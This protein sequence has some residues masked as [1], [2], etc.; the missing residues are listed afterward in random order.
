[1]RPL[2]GPEGRTKPFRSTQ[3]GVPGLLRASCPRSDARSSEGVAPQP[4]TPAAG[5]RAGVEPA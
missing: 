4:G 1:M 5:L 2:A 3:M